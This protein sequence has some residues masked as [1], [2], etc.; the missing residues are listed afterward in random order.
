MH[1]LNGISTFSKKKGTPLGVPFFLGS[2]PDACGGKA[3][4]AEYH[5]SLRLWRTAGT[6]PA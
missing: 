3:N 5:I 2:A 6:A 4:A 1:P